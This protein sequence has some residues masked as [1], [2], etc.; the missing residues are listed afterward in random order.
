MLMATIRAVRTLPRNISRIAVTSAMPTSRFSRTVSVV[1]VDQVG[2]VVVRDDLHARQQLAGLRCSSS[3]FAVTALEGRQRL[4]AL[5]EQDEALDRRRP[6]RPRPSLPSGRRERPAV[7]LVA[8]RL[9]DAALPGL[10]ADDDAGATCG[11]PRS[12]CR[13]LEHGPPS[14]T[15]STRTGTLLAVVTTIWRIS[16][17][18]RASS[19]RRMSRRSAGSLGDRAPLQRVLPLADQAEPAD[20]LD[21]LALHQ[22]VAA[23][24]GVAL[25]RWPLRSGRSVM[26]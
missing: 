19:A 13:R 21:G 25:R 2:A 10:V 6:R 3:I 15:C 16:R 14:T 17:S 8:G 12:R 20:H 18:R 24:V 7:R 4:L 22:V 26:P 5:A 11:R 9:M 1:T 23:D